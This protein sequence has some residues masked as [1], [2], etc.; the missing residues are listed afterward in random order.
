MYEFHLRTIYP[1]FGS[2]PRAAWTTVSLSVLAICLGLVIGVGSALL[3]GGKYGLAR[4]LISTYVQFMRNTPLIVLL[5][6]VFFGLPQL[7]FRLG[8]FGSALIAL[9]LNCSAYMI[10]IFR[11]GLS[12][13]PTGQ[14]EAAT[15]QGM[16]V[17]Q[18]FRHIVFPQLAR[19]VYAPLGNTFIQVLLGSSLASVVAVDE[20]TDWMEN[21]GSETFRFF[22]TFVV[23]GLMYVILCQTINVTRVLVGRSLFKYET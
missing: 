8:G 18:T 6:L 15:A 7:G 4:W 22:E 21:V 5:Y 19:I 3:R 10:E 17:W 14:Y 1:Y 12:A 11:G 9:T 13:I 23:A 16:T 2:L 20:L